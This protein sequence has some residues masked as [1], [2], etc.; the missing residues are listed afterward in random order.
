MPPTL[1][2]ITITPSL[3]LRDFISHY[4]LSLDNL[5]TTYIALPDGAV[6][7]VLQVHN[8]VAQSWIY[9]TTTARTE[10]PLIQ[11]YHY[12][13]IQF[14][15][16]QSRHFIDATARELTDGYQPTQ[17]LLQFWL[18][19]VPENV[20][21]GAI[22]HQLNRLLENYLAKRSPIYRKIDEAIH[23]IESSHGTVRI[24]EVAEVFGKSRRQFERVFLNIVG[25]SAKS[26]ATIMR[27]Q[28]ATKL[29]A[30][31]YRLSLAQAAAELG[32]SDQS[33]MTHEF[34]RLAS[35]SPAQFLQNHVAFLQDP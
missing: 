28:Q 10:V 5:D 2:H 34:Q 26:F 25:I 32:Y 31:P 17:G 11:H 35:T 33:H 24:G 12:L 15:P 27:F 9:G 13:G 22:S 4:W 29:I 21:T 1:N 14:K 6:D 19:D 30:P 7:L 20:A 3:Q 8:A 23:C 18:E 16:G